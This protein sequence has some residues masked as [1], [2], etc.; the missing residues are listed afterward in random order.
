MEDAVDAEGVG[1]A[2]G[3]ERGAFLEVE[4]VADAVG[5]FAGDDHLTATG[6]GLETGGHDDGVAERGEVDLSARV[7]DEPEDGIAD[8]E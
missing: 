8:V 2:L 3:L 4:V 1:D 5:Q 7:A 6:D